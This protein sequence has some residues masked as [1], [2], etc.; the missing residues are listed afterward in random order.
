MKA[1]EASKPKLQHC[2][3]TVCYAHGIDKKYLAV[4]S[5][6]TCEYQLA[7]IDFHQYRSDLDLR[8]THHTALQATRSKRASFTVTRSTAK[9]QTTE[10]IKYTHRP[11]G[12][13]TELENVGPPVNSMKHMMPSWTHSTLHKPYNGWPSYYSHAVSSFQ[14]HG[15][16]DTR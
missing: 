9:P 14:P 8:R 15:Q 13:R 16:T 10:T 11:H 7:R 5:W 1:L 4:V 6:Q 2:M 3:R 12:L